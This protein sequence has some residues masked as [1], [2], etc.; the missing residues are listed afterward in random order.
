VEALPQNGVFS[1][2]PASTSE[3]GVSD[4]LAEMLVGPPKALTVAEKAVDARRRRAMEVDHAIFER[5]ALDRNEHAFSE[6]YDR[7]SSRV[8]ALLLHMLRSEED[9][10]DLMQEIFILIW[11]KAPEFYE[12]RGNPA[13]WILTLA[14]N[15]AVDEM[16][17]KRYRKRKSEQSLVMGDDRPEIAELVDPRNRPDA[18]L[19]SK[20]A[21]FEIQRALQTLNAEQRET[22]D[23]A[24]FAG[25]TYSEIAERKGVPLSTVKSRVRQSVMKL[26]VIVKP[27]M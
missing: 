25:L 18:E 13:A 26:A 4:V 3:A 27:R 11:N 5:I 20:E 10:Q 12:S 21:Q 9:A 14:R 15:R 8:Y 6:L 22:I 1:A 7:F 24:Y 16:R 23:L 17:S 2:I 19:A